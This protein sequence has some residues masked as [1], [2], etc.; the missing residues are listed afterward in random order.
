VV[1]S[2]GQVCAEEIQGALSNTIIKRSIS[3]VEGQDIQRVC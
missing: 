2:Q 3:L 1:T